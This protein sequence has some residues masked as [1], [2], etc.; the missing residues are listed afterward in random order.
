[1][2][3]VNLT[4]VNRNVRF[5]DKLSITGDTAIIPGTNINIMYVDAVKVE[6]LHTKCV[7]GYELSRRQTGHVQE[8]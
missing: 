5:L 3:R 4:R 6:C 8:A 7:G 1:M 2:Q